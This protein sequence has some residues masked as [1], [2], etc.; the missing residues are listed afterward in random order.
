MQ[1]NKIVKFSIRKDNLLYE[2]KLIQNQICNIL[3]LPMQFAK[4]N[5]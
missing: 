2:L 4:C 3:L 5:Y 1:Y